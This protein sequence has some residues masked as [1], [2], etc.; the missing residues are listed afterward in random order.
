MARIYFE[1]VAP[2]VGAWI[3]MNNIVY[4][5]YNNNVAPLVGAWIEIVISLIDVPC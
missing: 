5:Y 3:E 2:L 4:G 1:P